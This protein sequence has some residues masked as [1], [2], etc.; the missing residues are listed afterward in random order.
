MGAVEQH[1]RDGDRCHREQEEPPPPA[2]QG[3][4][5]EQGTRGQEPPRHD[6]RPR[7]PPVPLLAHVLRHEA[8]EPEQIE[9]A[10]HA[11]HDHLRH[12]AGVIAQVADRHRTLPIGADGRLLVHRVRRVGD[13]AGDG[14]AAELGARERG[15]TAAAQQ[16]RA[17][18]GGE[19]DRALEPREVEHHPRGDG[20][21]SARGHERGSGESWPPG[22]AEVATGRGEREQ[23]H[24][25]RD[26]GELAARERRRSGRDTGEGERSALRRPGRQLHP[27]ER[28]VQQG[29]DA[30]HAEGLRHHEAV[31]HPQVGIHRG[32]HRGDGR[33]PA[34]PDSASEVGDGPDRHDAGDHREQALPGHRIV[35][36]ADERQDGGRERAVLGAR[37]VDEDLPEP[38]A[39]GELASLGGVVERVVEQQRL[40]PLVGDEHPESPERAGEHRPASGRRE[41]SDGDGGLL[42]GRCGPT[43]RGRPGEQRVMFGW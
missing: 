8:V 3:H 22:T 4:E 17:V 34:P 2:A 40:R 18:V 16:G 10:G 15:V 32:H 28:R 14:P 41:R 42:G 35:E 29:H 37:A 12:L 7:R 43:G 11:S 25:D 38:H 39:V 27:A 30:E 1:R 9:G 24:P 19:R 23:H 21:G 31:V 13:H 5:P 33:R 6:A 26:E 20:D 36:P